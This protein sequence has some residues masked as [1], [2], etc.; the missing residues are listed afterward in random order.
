MMNKTEA[1]MANYPN[2]KYKFNDRMP[3][4]LKGLCKGNIIYLNPNQSSEQLVGTLGEEIAHYLT[5][6]GDIITQDTNEKRKQEQKARD[7]GAT[8]VVSPAD[9][10]ECFNQRLSTR[11]ECAEYLGITV[12]TLDEATNVYATFNDGK[13][14]YEGH[15]IFFRPD[16]IVD[17]VKWIK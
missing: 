2:L 9:Y 8:L 15:T 6:V 13:L 16:G 7:L 17:V 3:E 5:S 11:W 10:I 1:L 12:E 4:K 14:D